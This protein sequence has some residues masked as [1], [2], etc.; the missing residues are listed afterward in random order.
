M[1]SEFKVG[2]E[3][4]IKYLNWTAIVT[5]V[6]P[7]TFAPSW[8]VYPNYAIRIPHLNVTDVVPQQALKPMPK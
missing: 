3:V 1:K 7:N 4:V 5:G 2:D 8:L 6:Y